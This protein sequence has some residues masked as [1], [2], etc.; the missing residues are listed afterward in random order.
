M[1]Y[2]R[3]EIVPGLWK[4]GS[5]MTLMAKEQGSVE[6]TGL[7]PLNPNEVEHPMF[8]GKS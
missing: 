5:R 8:K 4:G 3:V 2:F 6:I 1:Y 7:T